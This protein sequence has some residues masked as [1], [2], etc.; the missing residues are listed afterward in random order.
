MQV[1]GYVE[2]KIRTEQTLVIST[3]GRVKGEIIANHV[4]I[5][6][7]YD[8]TC[9]ANTIEI[10]QEGKASGTIYCDDLSIERGGSFLGETHPTS[11]ETVIA[12]NSQEDCKVVNDEKPK[13]IANVK[14]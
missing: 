6:G 12:I 8:G 4:V 10:L 2:G 5:N 7:L 1:D 13:K 9:Y 11:K 14:K 3:K